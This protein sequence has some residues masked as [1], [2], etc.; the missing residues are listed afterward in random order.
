MG[1]VVWVGEGAG[2]GRSGRWGDWSYDKQA[3][4]EAG[5][6]KVGRVR[7]LGGGEARGEEVQ[8]GGGRGATLVVRGRLRWRRGAVPL[9]EAGGSTRRLSAP[10]ER[11]SYWIV[12][13]GIVGGYLLRR[14]YV[15]RADGG[16]SRPA[17]VGWV[18][19]REVGGSLNQ[20]A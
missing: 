1:N 5:R 2:R 12:G 11:T 13:E 8:G 16:W 19:G 9:W 14:N 4:D 17:M 3:S 15:G 18:E 20:D 6:G 10:F 7:R